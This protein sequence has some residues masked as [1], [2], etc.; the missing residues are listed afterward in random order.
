MTRMLP[1]IATPEEYKRLF[2][3]PRPV[4]P[5]L[6]AIAQRHAFGSV[7]LRRFRY[8]SNFV[9]AAGPGRV[10]KLF[11]PLYESEFRIERDAL[12]A[13]SK[14]LGTAYPEILAEGEIEGWPYIVLRRI[15]GHPPVKVWKELSPADRLVVMAQLGEVIAALQ[16]APLPQEG[17][18]RVNW[19]IFIAS[20]LVNSPFHHARTGVAPGWID[21][22]PAFLEAHREALLGQKRRVLLHADLTDDNVLLAKRR[23]RWRLSGV[24]DFA[25][26]MV[27]APEYEFIAPAY[28][29]TR[30]DR[31]LLARLYEAAG[32]PAPDPE[33]LLAWTLLHR[34]A[35]LKA[36]VRQ[37]GEIAEGDY[38]ALARALFD[39]A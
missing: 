29:Y 33:R 19:P 14:T 36:Y 24:L 4:L 20:Q 7:T 5:A 26:A 32:H 3:D 22:L 13:A 28:M 6:R 16:R 9:Y 27:G 39:R 21:A 37:A 8:G 31:Q 1:T 15:S 25:D 17:P 2:D 34:F 12:T 38:P 10:V 35:H 30:G 11:A 18:V 23:G